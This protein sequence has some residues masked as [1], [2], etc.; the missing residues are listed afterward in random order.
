V[1][2]VVDDVHAGSDCIVE[3]SGA[4]G[5]GRSRF[6]H[7]LIER[8]PDVVVL[9]ARC[10]EYEASTPYYALRE[11]LRA[12]LALKPGADSTEIERRLEEVTARA[13]PTLVRWVPLLG[14]L[15]GVDLP[16]RA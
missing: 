1:L 16:A 8:C 13:D 6:V 2:A 12:V 3:V 11:P 15:P 4:P 9:R 7:E 5:V 14:I 10:E